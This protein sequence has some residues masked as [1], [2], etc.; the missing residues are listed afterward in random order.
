M[1]TLDG[2]DKLKELTSLLCKKQ[3]VYKDKVD[4]YSSLIRNIL[5]V[6]DEHSGELSDKILCIIT[7]SGLLE[8]ENER[9]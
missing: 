4:R 9:K 6:L 7:E 1:N 2:L 5:C 8:A 3:S